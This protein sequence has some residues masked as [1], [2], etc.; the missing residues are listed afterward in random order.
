MEQFKQPHPPP[1]CPRA[2]L[3]PLK[4]EELGSLPFKGRAGGSIEARRIATENLAPSPSRGGLGAVSRRAA[5]RRKTWLPPLQG[6]G[7]GGDGVL[8]RDK[9]LSRFDII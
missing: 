8:F 4:G 6:E 2:S 7:W 9:V 3:A 1:S 5:L